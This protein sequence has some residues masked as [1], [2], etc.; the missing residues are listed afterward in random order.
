MSGEAKKIM[1]KWEQGHALTAKDLEDLER[2]LE[3]LLDAELG[4]IAN[5][6]NSGQTHAALGRMTKINAFASAAI[7]QRPSLIAILSQRVEAFRS[8]LSAMGTAV[9]AAEFSISFGIP[10]GVSVSLTFIVSERFGG[11]ARGTTPPDVV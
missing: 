11:A 8:A 3:S 1:E 4:Q 10:S 7:Q 5:L 6:A 9:G 2:D